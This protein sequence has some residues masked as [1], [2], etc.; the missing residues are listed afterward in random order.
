MFQCIVHIE[1]GSEIQ[2]LLSA[3]LQNNPDS[4]KRMDSKG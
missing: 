1:T 2:S 3:K 4:Y